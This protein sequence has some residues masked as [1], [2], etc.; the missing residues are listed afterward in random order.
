MKKFDKGMSRAR[1]VKRR[2]ALSPLLWRGAGGEVG[3][4]MPDE[5]ILHASLSIV[6]C[7]LSI[8]LTHPLP[9]LK[10]GRC[11]PSCLRRAYRP[12]ELRGTKQEAIQ[13]SD[14]PGS[15]RLHSGSIPTFRVPEDYNP[16]RF[17]PSG[18]RKITIRGNSDLPGSGRLQSG[19]IPIFRISEDYNPGR[20]RPSGYRKITI[21][22]NSDLPGS[23]KVQSG[24]DSQCPKENKSGNNMKS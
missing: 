8:H 18:S 22:G 21:R 9:P 12:C 14:L 2:H 4:V 5:F 17:R 1:V 7:P 24:A 13:K 6:H 11:V 19:S 15:G 23:G 3:Y 10:R 16:G 20:F